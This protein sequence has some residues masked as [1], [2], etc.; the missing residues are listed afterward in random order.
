MIKISA[1]NIMAKIMGLFNSMQH[2][3]VILLALAGKSKLLLVIPKN[4]YEEKCIIQANTGI[5]NTRGYTDLLQ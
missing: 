2:C 4:W 5:P 3:E 1:D